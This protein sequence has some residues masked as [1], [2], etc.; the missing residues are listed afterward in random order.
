MVMGTH[1]AP[2]FPF[3][4][5]KQ[6]WDIRREYSMLS[7]FKLKEE[8]EERL[9]QGLSVEDATAAVAEAEA[10]LAAF[11]KDAEAKKRRKKGKKPA[12][13]SSDDGHAGGDDRP[14]GDEHPD[15]GGD[16]SDSEHEPDFPWVSAGC[17][18]VCRNGFCA[19]SV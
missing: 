19:S 2:T 6:L 18:V 14:S 11:K 7:C 10:D 17:I 9:I 12:K 8:L 1:N 5:Q 4:V 3:D 13:P 15:A 16:K